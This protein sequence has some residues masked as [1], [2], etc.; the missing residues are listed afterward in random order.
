[1]ASG[2]RIGARISRSWA[3]LEVLLLRIPGLIL[4]DLMP[5]SCKTH[6]ISSNVPYMCLP[7]GISMYQTGGYGSAA[8]I[9]G[10]EGGANLKT[11]RSTFLS[12]ICHPS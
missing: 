8:R 6:A 3:S 11:T 2:R 1:M 5:L 10:T 12:H 7:I 9:P 4:V